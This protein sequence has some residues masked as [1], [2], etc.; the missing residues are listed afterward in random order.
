ME[1]TELRPGLYLVRAGFAPLYL[2]RDGDTV[3]LI[4]TGVPGSGPAIEEALSSLG[5]SRAAVARI[6]VTHGHVDHAGS[7][8]Q[9]RAWHGAPVLV[10]EADAPFVT[11]E[12]PRPEPVLTDFDAP[13]WAQISAIE[14]PPTPPAT[15]DTRLTGGEE[16]DFGGG[17]R[18]L[19]IP[20]HTPGSIA[21]YLP[22]HK[23][24]FTGDTVAST[25]L[26]EVALGVF[27]QD[28]DRQLE[29][30]RQL[31][32]LDIETVCFGHGDP[33]V[34]GAGAVLREAVANHRPRTPV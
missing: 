33:V 8:A 27:N 34:T 15:V 2:W 10:H 30:F 22:A 12:T 6:V 7:A 23:V 24:L 5:L 14:F 9:V 21:V 16:L 13:L 26:G 3:T 19:S 17:A 1:I 25:S 11:G 32:A 31:A 20:G 4:D 28:G 29:S 18:V